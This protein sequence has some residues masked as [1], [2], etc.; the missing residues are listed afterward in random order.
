MKEVIRLEIQT[1]VNSASK[2]CQKDWPLEICE[3]LL[4][5]SK[6]WAHFLSDSMESTKFFNSIS[7]LQI[8]LLQKIIKEN[9]HSF[10]TK[11]KEFSAKNK[12]EIIWHNL[13]SDEKFLWKIANQFKV[14]SENILRVENRLY[15]D[16]FT[17]K[18]YLKVDGIQLDFIEEIIV[19]FEN[20]FIKL[21]EDFEKLKTQSTEILEENEPE[22]IKIVEDKMEI[23]VNEIISDKSKQITDYYNSC[24]K[25]LYGQDPFHQLDTL[26]T[27]NSIDVTALK[28]MFTQIQLES[29][30]FIE[31][32][33]LTELTLLRYYQ[34]SRASA[35]LS[36]LAKLIWERLQVDRNLI[37][38]SVTEKSSAMFY[39]AEMLERE[40]KIFALNRL[41]ADFPVLNNQLILLSM[42]PIT[43]DI[44][45][46]AQQCRVFYES[47]SLHAEILACDEIYMN[48]KVQDVNCEDVTIKL[49]NINDSFTKVNSTLELHI[50]DP[51]KDFLTQLITKIEKTVKILFETLPLVKAL[52]SEG[53]K[54]RHWEN[55][56]SEAE[57]SEEVRD[58]LLVK[59]LI[60]MDLTEKAKKCEEIVIVAGKELNLEKGLEKMKEQWKEMEIQFDQTQVG[61]ADKRFKL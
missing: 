52:K 42:E 13:E 7:S 47:S 36:H 28:T 31:N 55:L 6:Y 61:S 53:M 58:K 51:S 16:L 25:K 33:N 48:T 38:K 12:T 5:T 29:A 20:P 41:E 56:L 24:S 59:D 22:N 17:E 30:P 26:A 35:R 49:E 14:L 11:L 60:G 18:R 32:F 21:S 19:K 9:I 23:K 34:A 8:S 46:L 57:R 50:D 54:Q 4:S 2:I 39:E 40:L 1:F 44:P 45:A 15:P 43:I 10:I 37:E 3:V 27:V